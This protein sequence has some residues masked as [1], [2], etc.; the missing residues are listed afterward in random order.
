MDI[1]TEIRGG[2]P[3]FDAVFGQ[4]G[5]PV[6]QT[7]PKP[8]LPIGNGLG[9][10]LEPTA[11]GAHA[12]K[13]SS[14][15][16]PPQP[17]GLGGIDVESSLTKAAENLSEFLGGGVAELVSPSVSFPGSRHFQLHASHHRPW[18]LKLHVHGC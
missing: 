12:A 1:F 6:S 4:H 13:Q 17:V 10:I 8:P 16:P 3:D 11:V 5:Q 7:R 14:L 18:I 15:P 9:G 2:Q